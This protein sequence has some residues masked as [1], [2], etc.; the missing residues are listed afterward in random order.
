MEEKQP[1]AEIHKQV[2]DLL[3]D[4][5]LCMLGTDHS[6]KQ[7]QLC[8]IVNIVVRVAILAIFG[9]VPFVANL[10][11]SV[12][13]FWSPQFVNTFCHLTD[14]GYR[15]FEIRDDSR[16]VAWVGLMALG[17]GWHNNHHAFPKS[18]RH[19]M[20]WWEID[21]TWMIIWT[22]EKLGLA[23]D[24]VRPNLAL[25]DGPTKLAQRAKIEG[26]KVKAATAEGVEMLKQA[27]VEGAEI[28]KAKT[29]SDLVNAK[30]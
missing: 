6:A 1:V 9:W 3:E 16:N 2:P 10:I 23:K 24:V 13:V 7:A 11:A 19:G 25:L 22:L 8:L 21:I 4:K 30:S 18:A 20:K 27:T 28:L 5:V 29:E 17:E 15:N 12:M 26:A 14:H